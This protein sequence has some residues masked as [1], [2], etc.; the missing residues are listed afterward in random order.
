MSTLF[1][2]NYGP[3]KITLYYNVMAYSKNSHKYVIEKKMKTFKESI[4]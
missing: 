4:K 1:L 3:K 2:Q